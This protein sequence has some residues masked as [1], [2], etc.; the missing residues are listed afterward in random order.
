[1]IFSANKLGST[2]YNIHK[3]QRRG[4]T[5]KKR[6]KMDPNFWELYI[7]EE[8]KF[9]NQKGKCS[10]KFFIAF[11]INKVSFYAQRNEINS[12]R[13]FQFIF[14][15]EIFQ[16]VWWY[17][18]F[19]PPMSFS[20]RIS[21]QHLAYSYFSTNVMIEMMEGKKSEFFVK[22]RYG[23]FFVRGFSSLFYNLL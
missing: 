11:H 16:F 20:L 1:M 17:L 22:R 3:T 9:T 10:E 12:K 4:S 6:I 13:R 15:I 21:Y 2:M 18:V 8:I 5:E 23:L 19:F 7:H 14:K